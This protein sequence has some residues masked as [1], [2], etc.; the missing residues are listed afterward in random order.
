VITQNHT[1]QSLIVFHPEHVKLMMFYSTKGRGVSA[2][3]GRWY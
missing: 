2:I 3:I 1:I